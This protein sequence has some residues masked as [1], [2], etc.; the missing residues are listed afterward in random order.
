MA[1]YNSAVHA[2][3]K[4]NLNVESKEKLLIMA[5]EH[6]IKFLEKSKIEQNRKNFYESFQY[7]MKSKKIIRELQ[8]SLNM[9]IKEISLPL[10]RLYDYMDYRLNQVNVGLGV[11]EP[12]DEVIELLKGLKEAWVEAIKKELAKKQQSEQKVSINKTSEGISI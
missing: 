7:I 12:V 1:M 9:E 4:I 2:Y 11:M 5:Y 3:N 8:N 6:A 10:F